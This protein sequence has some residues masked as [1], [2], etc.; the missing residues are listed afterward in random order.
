MDR[1]NKLNELYITII[2]YKLLWLGII[3]IET[4]LIIDLCK[5]L[6]IIRAA[7]QIFSLSTILLSIV[8]K[9]SEFLWYFHNC[10]SFIR[11]LGAHSKMQVP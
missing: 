2:I 3:V 7:N 1:F 5:K 8:I 11:Q 9:I 10:C 6:M 4:Y